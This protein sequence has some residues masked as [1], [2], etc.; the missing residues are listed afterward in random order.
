[1]RYMAACALALLSTL[2]LPT[3]LAAQ[4][5]PA[6]QG[7]GG[8]PAGR[9]VP[10]PTPQAG[11]PID[12]TGYWVAVISEDWRWRMVTPPKG[13]YASIPLTQAGKD[14]ADQWDP[15]KDA[16]AGEQC[17]SYGAPGLMR[18]PTRL[19]ITWQDDR[20]LK[21]D[22]DYGTQTRLLQFGSPMPGAQ[23]TWQG[24]SAAEW[25]VA[26]GRGRG[27]AAAPRAGS[28]KVVTTNLRPGYLR[29]NGVPY[30]ADA[31]YSEYWDLF[32][33]PNGEQWIVITSV[34][35][36]PKNLQTDWI[37][38]LNFKKE[39]NGAKWSPTACSTTW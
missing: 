10:P 1:M 24:V 22:A 29:K 14:A 2:P 20:T 31:T 25:E 4:Q 21:V 9:G 16:A 8:A 15:A 37:T 35:H 36:D 32:P 5:A 6:P 26:G 18:A 7:R 30:S 3:P 23:A 38:S 11:A 33:R 34:V 28:L 27:A 19:H 39:A 12:L 13:D 17:K